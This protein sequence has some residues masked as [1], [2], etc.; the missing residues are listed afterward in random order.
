MPSEITMDFSFLQVPRLVTSASARTKQEKFPPPHLDGSI[1]HNL[2]TSSDVSEFFSLT[3][4]ELRKD[5]LRK[6]T[7]SSMEH[8]MRNPCRWKGG[9]TK[10]RSGVKMAPPIL[11][12]GF[13]PYQVGKPKMNGKTKVKD[14]GQVN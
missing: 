6:N 14:S 9:G 2:D 7:L 11:I 1:G 5:R 10:V 13:R 4:I 12:G 8:P 3:V